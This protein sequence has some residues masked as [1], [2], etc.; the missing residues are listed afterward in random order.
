MEV[1]MLDSVVWKEMQNRLENIERYVKVHSEYNMP[2]SFDESPDA[3]ATSSELAELFNLSLKTIYSWGSRG[4][5]KYLIQ[6]DGSKRYSLNALYDSILRNHLT[7][8]RHSKEEAL[9]KVKALKNY[10]LGYTDTLIID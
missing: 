10:L 6:D 1:I 8:K 2:M 7:I 5:I 9:S 3:N 4:I